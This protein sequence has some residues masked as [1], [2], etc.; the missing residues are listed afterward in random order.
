M[1]RIT[2]IFANSQLY[3]ECT[4]ARFLSNVK[5]LQLRPRFPIVPLPTPNPVSTPEGAI[6]KCLQ[7]LLLGQT[8]KL[9]AAG[10]G[11]GVGKCIRSLSAN[12][13]KSWH[14]RLEKGPSRH[15]INFEISLP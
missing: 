12:G 4:R 9:N 13:S 3:Q 1:G 5:A 8:E 2:A 6:A 14:G 15:L 7:Y 11:E 10:G